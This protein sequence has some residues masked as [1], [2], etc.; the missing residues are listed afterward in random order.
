MVLWQGREEIQ[1]CRNWW[2]DWWAAQ[3]HQM[4][5]QVWSL[6]T[7]S[8]SHTEDEI[9]ANLEGWIVEWECQYD[10]FGR[11]IFFCMI[12]PRLPENNTKKC[13]TFWTPRIVLWLYQEIDANVAGIRNLPPFFFFLLN[14]FLDPCPLTPPIGAFRPQISPLRVVLLTGSH[15]RT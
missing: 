9:Q 14:F 15:S 2:A 3:V 11:P 10:D 4:E 12:V 6:P 8:I 13:N 5:T 1:R 7:K